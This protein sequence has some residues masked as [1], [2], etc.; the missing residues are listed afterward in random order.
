MQVGLRL[1]SSHFLRLHGT[2]VEGG[3]FY[4]GLVFG[5]SMACWSS[6]SRLYSTTRHF[7]RF[8]LKCWDI[9]LYFRWIGPNHLRNECFVAKKHFRGC[10]ERE[11]A[12]IQRKIAR[13]WGAL[14]WHTYLTHVYWKRVL[15]VRRWLASCLGKLFCLGWTLAWGRWPAPW[16]TPGSWSVRALRVGGVG[17]GWTDQRRS[18]ENSLSER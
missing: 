7:P 9:N 16:R 8:S 13:I 10:I 14:L 5:N 17:W 1:V 2:L 6:K 3:D 18:V 4:F 12:R 15:I 11:I